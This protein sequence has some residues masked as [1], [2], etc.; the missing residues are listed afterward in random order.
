MTAPPVGHFSTLHLLNDAVERPLRQATLLSDPRDQQGLQRLES[1][2]G[3]LRPLQR[4]RGSRRDLGTAANAFY[5]CPR[6]ARWPIAIRNMTFL[7]AAWG[8]KNCVTSSSKN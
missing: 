5:G 1:A 4:R 6:R 8:E 2:A 3:Q 7:P